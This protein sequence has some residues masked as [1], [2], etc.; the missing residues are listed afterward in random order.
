[1]ARRVVITAMGMQS[2]LG[3]DSRTV[4]KNFISNQTRFQRFWV[5]PDVVVCPIDAFNLKAL[6]GR[7]K[8]RRYLNKGAA[9]SV[10]AAMMAV[11]NSK[12]AKPF[13]K[14]AGLMVGTGPN[15]DMEEEFPRSRSGLIQWRR[16]PAL[17]ML[18]FIANTPAALISQLAG[19]N[20]ESISI[21][22]ACTAG[23]QAVGEAF[24]KIKDGYLDLALAG[25]GDSRLSLSAMM[26][27]KKARALYKKDG[28]ADHACR[29]FDKARSGFVC[30]EGG[31]FFLLEPLEHARRRNA[32]VLAEITGYGAS[33]DA[34]GMTAPEPD[35]KLAEKA[36]RAS[37][38]EARI[39]PLRVQM[40]SAHG[41]GTNANDAT[42]VK[43]IERIFGSDGPPVMAL[44]SWIGH[45]SAACGAVELALTLICLKHNY[46][47]RIRNLTRPITSN[48]NFLRENLKLPVEIVLL[49]NF[50]F[51]GQNC[52]LVVKKMIAT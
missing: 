33:M 38:T 40:I 24:R 31:A 5:D 44:K 6:I 10:G 49:Q 7:C 36:V 13:L 30:G 52:A 26:A 18:K 37:L 9:F 51:G 3:N 11:G 41:T 34:H 19:I 28:I 23:L 17:W 35:G 25:A 21:Q 43:V 15:L 42:E 39:S 27:Y 12:L 46:W 47:P 14:S 22:T 48:V 50:G 2:S 8:N 32:P 45:L 16:T 4:L 1:M 29:P 20:G